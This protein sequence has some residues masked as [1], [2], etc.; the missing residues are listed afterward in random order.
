MLEVTRQMAAQVL[1]RPAMLT[2]GTE[3]W[4]FSMM[5]DGTGANWGMW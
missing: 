1:E 3:M 2:M 5:E 4:D